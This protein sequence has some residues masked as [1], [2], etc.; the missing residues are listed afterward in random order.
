MKVSNKKKKCHFPH[1][2]LPVLHLLK[3]LSVLVCSLA[4]LGKKPSK[5][6]VYPQQTFYC[7]SG[8]Q[9]LLIGGANLLMKCWTVIISV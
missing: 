9:H 8:F 6:S 1:K 2:R 7:S 4:L 5:L 3:L